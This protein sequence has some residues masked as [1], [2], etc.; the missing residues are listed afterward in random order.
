M[1]RFIV[2]VSMD[3]DFIL[4]QVIDNCNKKDMH[5]VVYY[6]NACPLIQNFSDIIYQLIIAILAD[7]GHLTDLYTWQDPSSIH[8]DI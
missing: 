1:N 4:Q 2:V 6:S 5:E 8:R 7:P 3:K